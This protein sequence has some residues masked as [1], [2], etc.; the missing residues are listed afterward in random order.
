M[1]RPIRESRETIEAKL[2][3][4]ERARVVVEKAL[5]MIRELDE[6][7]ARLQAMENEAGLPVF[8]RSKPL[9][10]RMAHL[11]MSQEAIAHIAELLDGIEKLSLGRGELSDVVK[12]QLG[13]EAE[14]ARSA[15]EQ[16]ARI[17]KSRQKPGP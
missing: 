9:T 5:S 16:L 3:M 8:Y 1:T 6:F 11:G 12:R 7:E 13:Q 14:A 2:Q 17:I 4:D 15:A 10:G